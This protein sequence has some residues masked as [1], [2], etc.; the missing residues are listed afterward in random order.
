[1]KKLELRDALTLP[2]GLPNREGLVLLCLTDYP[3]ASN[4]Y[5]LIAE[6]DEWCFGLG[7]TGA[8]VLDAGGRIYGNK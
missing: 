1:V 5:P 3:D 6:C 4:C 8:A 2:L 7:G